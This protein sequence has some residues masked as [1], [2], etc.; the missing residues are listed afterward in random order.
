VRL[1]V[2]TIAARLAGSLEGVRT[3]DPIFALT[4]DD[5]P[6]PANTAPILAV[7]AEHAARATF[8]VIVDNAAREPALV[9]EI[10]GAGHEIALHGQVHVDLT[11]CSRREVVVHVRGARGRLEQLVGR[12]VRLFRPPYGTQTWFSYGVARVSGMEVVGW[13]SSPRD[14]LAVDLQRQVALAV[15][16]LT[17]GGV[18]LLHDG[19]VAAP[20]QRS[21]V[22][23]NILVEVA[24]RGFAAVPVGELLDR[25]TPVRRPWFLHRAEAMLE[26][27]RPFYLKADEPDG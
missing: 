27:L 18:M 26:E 3:S 23:Q 24:R 20:E 7:L 14:F 12:P 8:F 2:N 22:L 5:G 21:R 4:F 15:N 11:R 9:A 1:R 25:G 19:G 17:P 6:H 13:S 10:V 16:E